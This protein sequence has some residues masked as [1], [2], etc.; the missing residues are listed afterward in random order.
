MAGRTGYNVTQ[1][2][3]LMENI[4][5]CYNNLGTTVQSGWES[6]STTLKTNWVGEDEQDFEAKL[7]E[8]ISN[9]YVNTYNLANNSLTTIYDLAKAWYDFQAKNKLEGGGATA[10]DSSFGLEQIQLTQNDKIVEAKIESIADDVD[11]GL[12]NDGSSA[13]VKTALEE[14]KTSVQTKINEMID[15]VTV[16]SAFFGEQVTSI[17]NFVNKVGTAMGEVVSAIKDMYDALDTLADSSYTSS[18]TE[19]TSQM[20]SASSNIESSLSDLGSSRWT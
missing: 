4:E 2:K 16:D 18:S 8:R 7:A 6:L 3:T 19:V 12:V 1:T 15:A 10:G 20:E 5:E 9:M 17:K 13:A 11:R 14:Y